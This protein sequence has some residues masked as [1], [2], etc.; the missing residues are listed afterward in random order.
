MKKVVNTNVK[1][2]FEKRSVDIFVLQW[3]YF[4]GNA[5]ETSERGGGAYMDFSEPIYIYISP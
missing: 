3:N 2:S 5:G 1:K 4:R